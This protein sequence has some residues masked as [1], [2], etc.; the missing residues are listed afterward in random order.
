IN[1]LKEWTTFSAQPTPDIS[2]II[3]LAL[4]KEIHQ[5]T[6][7]LWN[8]LGADFIYHSHPCQQKMDNLWKLFPKIPKF[9]LP[10]A[11]KWFNLNPSLQLENPA[12]RKEANLFLALHEVFSEAEMNELLLHEQSQNR[13]SATPTP[14]PARAKDIAGGLDWHNANHLLNLIQNY[15][16]KKQAESIEQPY[17]QYGMENRNAFILN[18][19]VQPILNSGNAAF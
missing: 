9:L 19:L 7:L 15:L 13:L 18:K 17:I 16:P 1:L 8:S 11:Y 4:A 3:Q 2:G 14:E 10:L 12:V 6:Q 5:E